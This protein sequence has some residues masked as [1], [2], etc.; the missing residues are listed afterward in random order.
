MRFS[1]R[2][3]SMSPDC[4]KR[5]L[6]D[7][8][9]A[10]CEQLLSRI[11]SELEDLDEGSSTLPFANIEVSPHDDDT[12]ISGTQDNGTWQTAGNTTTWRNKMLGDGGFAGFDAD[13]RD[14]RF[15]TFT[16]ASVDVNFSGGDI[17]Q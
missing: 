11:P 8:E 10:R 16:G 15:H 3:A 14:F 17:G 1:G 7:A 13:K 2:F 9:L 6:Q 12:L 5:G 4:V